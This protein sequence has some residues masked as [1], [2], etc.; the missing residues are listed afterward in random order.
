ML[1]KFNAVLVATGVGRR[2]LLFVPRRPGHYS[3]N[4]PYGQPGMHIRAHWR[5]GGTPFT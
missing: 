5:L 4:E 1:I 3:C 2:A